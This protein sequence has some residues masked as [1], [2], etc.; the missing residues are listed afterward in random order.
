MADAQSTYVSEDQI[1]EPTS[2]HLRLEVCKPEEE[3]HDAGVPVDT[4][5]TQPDQLVLQYLLKNATSQEKGL[6]S[7]KTKN[8]HDHKVR[9][10]DLLTALE[11]LNDKDDQHFQPTVFCT[12]D[13]KDVP[14]HPPVLRKLLHT[15]IHWASRVV[16][17]PTDVVFITHLALYFVTSLPSAIYLFFYNFT[18]LHG[19]IHSGMTGYYFGSYTLMMHNHIHNG[20]ILSRKWWLLDILFPYLTDP[21][22]GHTWNSYYYHHVKHHHVEG[23]G[24]RDLSST[25]RLQRDEISSLLYYVGRFVFC[26]WL[27]LPLY[28][29]RTGKHQH[30]IRATFWEFSSYLML[31]SATKFSPKASAFVLLVPFSLIRLGLMIGNFGQHAFVDELDPESDFRSSITLIDVPVSS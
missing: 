2:S 3:I 11:A 31:L 24:P 17:R 26:I 30:A 6:E 22:M 13:L 4:N 7:T 28:F 12:W 25:V 9:E 8:Q 16:R 1:W 19:I 23:N 10:K 14:C 21:L 18:W 20:G 15:Y 29:I 27:D 5:L